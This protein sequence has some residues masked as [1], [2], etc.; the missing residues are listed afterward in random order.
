MTLVGEPAEVFPFFAS[1]ANLESITPPWL[2]FRIVEAPPALERGARLRYRLRIRG[3][4]VSW[5][6]E[7]TEWEPPRL[8]ADSQLRGPYRRWVHRHLF[9]PTGD[10]RTRMTDVVDFRAPGGPLVERLL[11]R[12]DVLRIFRY[13]QQ[14]LL[15][16]FGGDPGGVDVTVR[17]M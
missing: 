1:A 11:V 13:R 2:R 6:T 7:I 10:G 17:P 4:P 5:L 12:P 8:F 14:R 16:R 3:V 15:D 9:E